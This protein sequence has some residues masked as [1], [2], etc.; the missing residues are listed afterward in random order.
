MLMKSCLVLVAVTM[1]SQVLA[2]TPP[3]GQTNTGPKMS[4]AVPMSGPAEASTPGQIVAIM[5][6]VARWQLAQPPMRPVTNDWTYGALYAGLMA[7]TQVSTAPA[8][9]DRNLALG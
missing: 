1:V 8:F 2:V 3:N 5:E 6:K 4:V 9:H 7:L